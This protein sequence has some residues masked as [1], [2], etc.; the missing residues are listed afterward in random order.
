MP[1]LRRAQHLASADLLVK[2]FYSEITKLFSEVWSSINFAA[3][4]AEQYVEFMTVYSV[5]MLIDSHYP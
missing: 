2:S 3:F 5:Q 1:V 4:V